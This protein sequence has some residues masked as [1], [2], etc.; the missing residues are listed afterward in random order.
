[1]LRSGH[2]AATPSLTIV[3]A[4]QINVMLFVLAA[5]KGALVEVLHHKVN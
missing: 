1:M 4:S 5:V 3:D 2:A